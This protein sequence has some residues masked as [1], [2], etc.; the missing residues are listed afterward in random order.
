M[1]TKKHTHEKLSVQITTT[2]CRTLKG[3]FPIKPRFANVYLE[4]KHNLEQPN[5]YLQKKMDPL[6]QESI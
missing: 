4:R 1:N 6:S 3:L 2:I 5:G